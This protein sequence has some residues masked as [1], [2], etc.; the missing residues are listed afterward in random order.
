MGKSQERRQAAALQMSARRH[1][2]M[3]DVTIE[4]CTPSP[5]FLQYN[6]QVIEKGRDDTKMRAVQY[7]ILYGPD[8][9]RRG[10]AY[11]LPCRVFV[12]RGNKGLTDR[13]VV[14]RGNKGV[15]AFLGFG[16]RC[17]DGFKA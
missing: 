1:V 11:P 15:R 13:I 8:A 3:C 16:Q 14:S 12:S 9:V 5:C 17:E 2:M 10:N 7:G 6:A 4:L